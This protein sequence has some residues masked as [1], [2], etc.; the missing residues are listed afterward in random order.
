MTE[1]YSAT[2]ISNLRSYRV[3]IPKEIAR[4]LGLRKGDALTVTSDNKRIVFE[5]EKKRE[6]GPM[7]YSIGYEGKSLAAFLD[8]LS[9]NDVKQL[10]DVRKNAFSF[11]AGFSKTPLK[12]A[13]SNAGIVYIHIP[14]LGTD[15]KSRKEYKETGDISRLLQLYEERLDE[16]TDSYET[17]KALVNYRKSALMCFEDDYTRCHRSIIENRLKDD[18]ISVVHLCSGKPNG[19]S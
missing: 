9:A 4:S 18:D 19:S 2:V 10:I 7:T 11:K 17:L 12:E 15:Q 13:L 14:E 1:R 8:M 3:T 5:L 6:K 16:N